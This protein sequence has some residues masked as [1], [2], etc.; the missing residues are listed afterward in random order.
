MRRTLRDDLF[1]ML[2]IVHW[3]GFLLLTV[4][5]TAAILRAFSRLMFGLDL[6]EEPHL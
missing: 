5:I 1:A 6:D 2:R 3:L 4:P